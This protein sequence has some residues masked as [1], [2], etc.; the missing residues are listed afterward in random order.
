[1][2]KIVLP[3]LA[4]CSQTA[5]LRTDMLLDRTPYTSDLCKNGALRRMQLERAPQPMRRH[6]AMWRARRLRSEVVRRR[7]RTSSTES[8]VHA[9][10]HIRLPKHCCRPFTRSRWRSMDECTPSRSSVMRRAT[11]HIPCRSSFACSDADSHSRQ[12]HFYLLLMQALMCVRDRCAPWQS[13]ARGSHLLWSRRSS[14]FSMSRYRHR[15][16]LDARSCNPERLQATKACQRHRHD[17]GCARSG[18]GLPTR[19]TRQEIATIMW[20]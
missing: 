6:I 3:G 19:D 7:T 10:R 4:R 11:H 20:G 2:L 5:A 14:L 8:A 1:M 13:S 9:N 15:A 18:A 16:F 12:Q 17:S